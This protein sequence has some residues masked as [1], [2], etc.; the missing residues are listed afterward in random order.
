MVPEAL[1]HPSDIGIRQSGIGECAG[2]CL[3]SFSPGVRELL[4]RNIVLSGGSTTYKG[5]ASRLQADVQK[6][7][8]E[9]LEEN[10]RRVSKQLG[11]Q[12]AASKIDVKIVEHKRQQYAV[13]YG[14]AM[15]AATGKAFYN[16]CITKQQYDEQG[17]SVARKSAIFGE[18]AV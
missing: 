8:D 9:Q 11:R 4:A 5:L 14:G 3:Q 6:L 15:L 1:F 17:P 18:S 13:W 12:I 10:A 7:V 16:L 2:S